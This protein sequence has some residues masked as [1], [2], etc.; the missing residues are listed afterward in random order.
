MGL[1]ADIDKILGGI[2]KLFAQEGRVREVAILANSHVKTEQTSSDNWNGGTYGYTVNLQLAAHHYAQ[3]TDN[4][5]DIE[6]LLNEKA[7]NLTRL[8]P[9]EFIEAFIIS[10]ELVDDA[11][12]RDR[13]KLWVSGKGVSNQ[14]RA[15]SDNVAPLMVDGLLFRSHPEIHLYRALKTLGVTFAP[16][17]VFVRGGQ[18]YRRLEPDFVILK[19][20]ILMILEVDGDTVHQETPQEAHDRLTMLQHEGAHIERVNA[21]ECDTPEK[22]KA[23]ATTILNLFAKLRTNK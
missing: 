1:E 2:A 10:T 18:T 16:L 4:Q 5:N 14:G 15:R 9:N 23:C 13:A 12:W 11:G 3:L 6:I 21:K 19:D 8:Y 17:P 20:G 7:K 22:A